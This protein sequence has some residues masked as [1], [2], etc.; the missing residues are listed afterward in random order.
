MTRLKKLL[1]NYKDCSWQSKVARLTIK[2]HRYS[3][4]SDLLPS[5]KWCL[6]GWIALRNGIEVC[7]THWIL[8]LNDYQIRQITLS[9]SLQNVECSMIIYTYYNGVHLTTLAVQDAPNGAN[10]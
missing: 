4:D 9:I 2:N 1:K 6:V 3:G 7:I 10:I 8:T 5:P